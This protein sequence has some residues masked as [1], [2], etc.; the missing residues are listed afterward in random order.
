[1]IYEYYDNEY[2]LEKNKEYCGNCGK[3]KED[4]MKTKKL[5]YL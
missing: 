5:L 1:M 4:Y 3:E 2:Q